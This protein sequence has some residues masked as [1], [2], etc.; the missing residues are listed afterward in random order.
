LNFEFK[1][2]IEGILL[3]NKMYKE[4]MALKASEQVGNRWS[5]EEITIFY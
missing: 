4:L 1:I 3:N 2:I 5:K